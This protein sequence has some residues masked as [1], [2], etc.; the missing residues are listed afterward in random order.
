MIKEFTLNKKNCIFITFLEVNKK[1]M[2]YQFIVIYKKNVLFH[3]FSKIEAKRFAYNFIDSHLYYNN[4]KTPI[5]NTTTLY[6]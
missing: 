6:Y 3:S 4:Y 5:I 1:Y 2:D